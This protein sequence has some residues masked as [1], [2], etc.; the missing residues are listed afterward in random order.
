[1]RGGL[2]VG[3]LAVDEKGVFTGVTTGAVDGISG[4]A[5]AGATEFSPEGDHIDVR[6]SLINSRRYSPLAVAERD[7]IGRFDDLLPKRAQN[8]REDHRPLG[9]V[10]LQENYSWSFAD[11]RHM[12]FFHWVIQNRG[13]P[14]RNVYLGLY[15]ELASGA[16]NT[17]PA[18]P[19][20][21]WFNK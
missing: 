8:N 19:P 4:D 18:W 15:N 1:V 21:G 7:L 20:A 14:L 12:V 2:W 11:Y 13:A 17:S 5:T 9:I 16:K 6:S 10:V 3:A